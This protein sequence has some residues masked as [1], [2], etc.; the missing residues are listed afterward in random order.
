MRHHA[1]VVVVILCNGTYRVW[2]IEKILPHL[3]KQKNLLHGA[4]SADL[5]TLPQSF[6][7]FTAN[8]MKKVGTNDDL[9]PTAEQ[10]DKGKGYPI[11][12]A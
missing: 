3:I 2:L 7:P 12:L 8:V 1:A 10:Q 11:I 9:L 6:Q 4:A 5:L